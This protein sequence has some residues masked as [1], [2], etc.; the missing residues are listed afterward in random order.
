[1]PQDLGAEFGALYGEMWSH[2]VV[3]H[4]TKEVARMRNARVTECRY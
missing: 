4:P 3:D 1:M 2:G